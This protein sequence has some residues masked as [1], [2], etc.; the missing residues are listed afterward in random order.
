MTGA[1]GWI[2]EFGKLTTPPR[3][4]PNSSPLKSYHSKRTVV[5][6]PSFFKGLFWTTTTTTA[7]NSTRIRTKETKSRTINLRDQKV[8]VTWHDYRETR[9]QDPGWHP[10]LQ[11]PD[12]WSKK[13]G[14]VAHACSVHSWQKMA[15][16]H[17]LCW[18]TSDVKHEGLRTKTHLDIQSESTYGT[19]LNF[20]H[21][22]G[23]IS[24]KKSWGGPLH[25]QKLRNLRGRGSCVYFK[26]LGFGQ[27]QKSL[28][29]ML[30]WLLWSKMNKMI[31]HQWVVYMILHEFVTV[32]TFFGP[33]TD[34]FLNLYRIV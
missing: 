17:E 29:K 30:Q 28:N 16:A 10:I 15:S 2:E 21:F 18:K 24:Q 25:T 9:C 13:N 31:I 14:P 22:P 3:A 23:S 6:Q 5:F 26:P 1:Q 20:P 27:L 34:F 19:S 4:K 32:T 33:N 11:D 7:T 8:S 12:H